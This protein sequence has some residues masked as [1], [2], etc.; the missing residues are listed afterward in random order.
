MSLGCAA[1]LPK[2]LFIQKT[3]TGDCYM[4]DLMPGNEITRNAWMGISARGAG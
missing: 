1:S 2:S 4:P 3:F